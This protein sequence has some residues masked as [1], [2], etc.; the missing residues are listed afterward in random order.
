[1]SESF[2]QRINPITKIIFNSS[3]K[4][5]LSFVGSD[6]L[7]NKHLQRYGIEVN[8]INYYKIKL[9]GDTHYFAFYLSADKKIA[10]MRGY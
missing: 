1:M 6:K 4:P 8:Q 10:D 5:K 2:I 9:G 3:A 7:A